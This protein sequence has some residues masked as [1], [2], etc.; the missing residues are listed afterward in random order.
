MSSELRIRKMTIDDYAQ[1]YALWLDTTGL[2]LNN[3]DDTREGIARYLRRNPDTS[4]LAERDGRLVGAILCGHDGRRGFIHHT[5]VD[6]REQRG[7]I[8]SALVEAALTALKVEGI[9]KVVLTAWVSNEKG[10]AFW[11]KQ[12]FHIRYDLNYRDKALA[13]LIYKE[14]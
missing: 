2:G 1:V 3:L 11:E 13:E 7:G 10:N 9:S 12:G 6:A 4:F 5:A 14:H 8:G